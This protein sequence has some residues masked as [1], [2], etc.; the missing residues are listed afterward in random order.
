MTRL[1]LYLT[2]LAALATWR[3]LAFLFDGLVASP[4]RDKPDDPDR[5]IER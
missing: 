2:V 5:Y 4:W 3:G 1:D